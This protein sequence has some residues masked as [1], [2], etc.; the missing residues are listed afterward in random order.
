MSRTAREEVF[1]PDE[2]AI[3]HTMNRVVRRCLLF[4]TDPATNISYD[5]RKGWIEALLERFA[6]HFGIDLIAYSIL[7]NHFHLVLRNRPDVVATWDDTEVARRWL[8]ICPVRKHA[9][10]QPK[11]PKETEINPIRNDPER[12]QEIRSRLSDI[13]WWMRLLCQRIGMRAN[14]E[15]NATGKFFEARFKA[16]R[17]LDEAAVAAC[18]AYVDLNPI[19][20]ALAETLEESPYTSVQR[21]IQSMQ[22]KRDADRSLAPVFIDERA[23]SFLTGGV[24]L[25]HR[26]SNL[27]FL[28]M[29]AAEYIQLLDWTSR[30]AA[31]GK[32]GKTPENIPPVLT[33][34]GIDTKIWCELAGNFGRLFYQV[35]GKPQTID[36]QRS[37]VK[38]RQF[39][40][41]RVARDVFHSAA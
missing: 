19:R 26:C 4:G 17:L 30:Q 22:V 31:P 23:S 34:L 25:V 35:A 9:D 41:R 39:Y 40:M 24:T 5:H 12:L 36:Q 33:R 11:E 21:R 14:R 10:G 8:M 29:T 28:P 15:D 6:A 7:S 32:H 37:R 27:G 1:S 2:I 18:V 38:Q 3:V 13:S 20:A 16:V